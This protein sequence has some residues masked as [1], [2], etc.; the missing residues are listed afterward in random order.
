MLNIILQDRN[1]SFQTHRFLFFAGCLGANLLCLDR[2][3]VRLLEIFFHCGIQ[4]VNG[5]QN[6]HL[7]FSG[8]GDFIVMFP[9]NPSR[10]AEGMEPQANFQSSFFFGIGQILFGLFR[11]SRR[12][13]TRPSNSP[14]IS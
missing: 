1:I 11:L 10:M 2:T 13:S 4:L 12:G 7:L 5:L 3:G 9:K 14:T 6:L 8:N